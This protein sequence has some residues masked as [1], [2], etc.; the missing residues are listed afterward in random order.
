MIPSSSSCAT[1]IKRV[2]SSFLLTGGYTRDDVR[3][4]VFL[5]QSTMPTFPAHWAPCSGSIEEGEVPWQT[6]VRELYEETN[7]QEANNVSPDSQYGLYVDV[8]H[9]VGNNRTIRMYPFSVR[10][11][12]DWNLELRGTEHDRY[13]YVSV[14]DLECL[15][16]AVPA[17][18]T[19]F[20][21]ATFGAYLPDVP[22]N[23][24]EWAGDHVNGAAT[25]ARKALEMV[26]NGKLSKET[27]Q[28]MRM[29]RPTMVAIT[30][31]LDQL[32][33]HDPET[34]LQALDVET[35]RAVDMAVDYFDRILRER[36]RESPLRV[37]T[38][39]RSSTL[40]K[41]LQRVLQTHGDKVSIECSKSTPG[42]EGALMAHDLGGVPCREDDAIELSIQ[43]GMVD[44]LL[45][46]ADVVL[47][48]CI[49]NKIGTNR[50]AQA[51]AASKKCRVV[52]SSD[53]FKLWSDIFPPPLES[54]FECISCNLFDE[55][56]VPKPL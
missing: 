51:A 29:M 23:V 12:S 21:H 49:V 1:S 46:G 24:R 38:F 10:V 33:Q 41:I 19:T 32:Q 27:V 52:C 7:L 56:L 3:I 43:H 35:Q 11:P 9:P 20:H 54:I 18:A 34:A 26:Q 44:V 6:A 4:A 36:S 15:E 25:L 50:L 45:V 14:S 40:V 17:L 53:R 13:E 47:E 22:Y 39:S 37:V 42:D 28:R 48:D 55:I 5:R 8:P 31:A 2:V 16:P 30:N